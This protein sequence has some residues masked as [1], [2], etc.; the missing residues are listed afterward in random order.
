MARL[1]SETHLSASFFA[2]ITQPLGF[3][4]LLVFR[5]RER[6]T[7]RETA[8]AIRTSA[9]PALALGLL[10]LG[11]CCFPVRERADLLV[12]GMADVPVDL[13]PM[14]PADETPPPAPPIGKMKLQIPPGLPGG[15]APPIEI[16]RPDDPPEKKA[17]AFNKLYPEL[18]ALGPNPPIQ[19]GPNGVP[20]A[21][22]DLQRLA[23]SNSPLIRQAAADVQAARGAVIQAGLYPNPSIGLRADDIGTGV[24]DPKGGA[25]YQG[26]FI[27]QL[28]KTGGKLGLAQAAARMD[29]FNAELALRRAQTDLAAQVRSGYFQA[30]V[31]LES[32]RINGLLVGFTD[33][34]FKVQLAKARA[35]AAAAAAPYEPMQLRVLAYQ[36]RIAL[37]QARNNYTTAWKQLAATLG[38]PGM[39]PTELAGRADMPVPRYQY[40]RVL[41]RVLSEHTDVGTAQNAVLK[42]RYH[43]RRAQVAVVPD[44]DIHVSVA[45]D[46]TTPPFLITPSV[47]VSVPIPIWDRNQGGIVQAQAGLLRA[48]EEAHRVR[49]SLTYQLASAFNHYDT[50]LRSL[51]KYR[52]ALED[53]VRVFRAVYE[54]HQQQPNVVGFGD[55][56]T[57]QQTLAGLLA[58]YIT[59]LQQEWQAVVEVASL[60]QTDDLFQVQDELVDPHC[61]PIQDLEQL[62]PLRCCHRSSPMPDTGNLH[63]ADGSWPDPLPVSKRTNLKPPPPKTEKGSSSPGKPQ[64]EKPHE[65]SA[66][67]QV[68]I[69]TS[70]DPARAP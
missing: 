42:A 17:A 4:D 68:F 32:V 41:A 43:L 37:I 47:N 54:R 62:L 25:G 13:Q 29:L 64:S 1:Q 46:Y 63:A 6:G 57:A 10:L 61:H 60:M 20:L 30:L 35:G 59:T 16:A 66:E 44:V 56:V 23:L 34:A 18:P 24:T 31:A 36:A 21:L 5:E 14:V 51:E 65:R 70:E 9:R 8:M 19:H 22:A 33:D 27:D 11:G 52:L 26:I 55:I 53:Q 3:P 12:H 28:I 45:K 58:N 38:E 48:R 2:W 67:P 69:L 39:P 15:H 50:N 49:D 7:E 40:D